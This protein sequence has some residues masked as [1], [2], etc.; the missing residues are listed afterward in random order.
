[1]SVGAVILAG[2]KGTR[3]ANP[4]IP[5]L[6]QLVGGKSLLEWHLDLLAQSQVREVVI[7]SG[8]LGDQ[9]AALAQ[10]V[11]ELARYQGFNV[12][13]VEEPDPQGTVTALRLGANILSESVARILVMLGDVL[14]A[15]PVEQFLSNWELSGKGVAVVAHPNNH[16]FDSDSVYIDSTGRAIAVP[17]GARTGRVPNSA[18]AGLF[19]IT[20][21]AISRYLSARDFGSNLLVQ[22]AESNDL[23]VFTGSHY[24]KDTGT[25]DRLDATVKDFEGGVISR[26]GDI[27]LRRA[28]FLDRDGVI[29]AV[30]PEVYRAKDYQVLP[31][32]A[33]EI[34]KANELGI[35]V[36]VVTNQPGIA[37]GLMSPEEHF[38]IRSELD[39]QL[40]V[41]QAFV[42][43]YYFCPH[44]PDSGFE[45]ERIA[46]K[47]ECEC[48]KPHAALAKLISLQH[49]IEL[50]KSIMVGDTARD[51]GLAG[52][53]G[54]GFIH[55]SSAC[56][57]ESE[58]VCEPDS[59]KAIRRAVEEL[60]C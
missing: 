53:A 36:F 1:V 4:T 58:H 19:A 39:A 59:V 5:K 46:L 49:G 12:N 25:P 11:S 18:S 50:S 54:M 42:D 51:Q 26:R 14:V 45:G 43:E 9:V 22:A 2:G 47:V 21:A 52:N 33:S 57:L 37:K 27:G 17:K 48:R 31:G 32:V 16:P 3:S 24:L 28:L 44:H 60:A 8:H 20:K 30:Q 10:K 29:N 35:P 38:E 40:G 13:T 55:V 6:A 34:R 41:E 23:F 56:D 15:M 7:V